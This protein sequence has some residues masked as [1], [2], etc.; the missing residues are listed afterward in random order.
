MGGL[1]LTYIYVIAL[2]ELIIRMMAAGVDTLLVIF[3]MI[4]LH[5]ASPAGDAG[6][7]WYN[8]RP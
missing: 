2:K 6:Y 4:K 5:L 3:H 1:S 8:F 7:K